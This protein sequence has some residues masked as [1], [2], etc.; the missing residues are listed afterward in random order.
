[1]GSSA[2]D[3]WLAGGVSSGREA[4]YGVR[5]RPE[6][7]RKG[8]YHAI[9]SELREE[10]TV[11]VRLRAAPQRAQR[12]S[13]FLVEGGEGGEDDFFC[14]ARDKINIGK[15]EKRCYYRI[16][17]TLVSQ[18][19]S[20]SSDAGFRLPRFA[21]SSVAGPDLWVLRELLSRPCF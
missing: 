10:R 12:Q 1:M 3:F 6:R 15:G 9:Y 11:C 13:R 18:S 17:Y 4:R 20:Q 5:M 19:V 8:S 21:L 2:A 14:C 16:Q 7:Q